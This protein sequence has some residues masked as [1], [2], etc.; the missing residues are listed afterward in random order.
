[1]QQKTAYRTT[2]K[3]AKVT[4]DEWDFPDVPSDINPVGP[5]ITSHLAWLEAIGDHLADRLEDMA[6]EDDIR[7]FGKP[8][9][10]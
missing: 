3:H 8:W 5:E 7:C 6:Y 10:Y 4:P 2:P 1:M 9:E